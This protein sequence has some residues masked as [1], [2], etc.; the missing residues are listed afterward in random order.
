VIRYQRERP[1]ELIHMDIKKLGRFE[2][3][4]HRATGERNGDRYRDAGWECVHVAIN[5]ATRLAYVEVLP[6]E[7]RA[8]TTGFMVRARAGSGSAASKSSAG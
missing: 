8:T 7:K 2:K 3:P 5:D 1:G 6:D 4:G